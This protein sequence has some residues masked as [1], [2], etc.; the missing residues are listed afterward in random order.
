MD[1][2]AH[3][4][5]G[6]LAGVALGAIAFQGGWVDTWA[7]GAALGGLCAGFALFPDL[8]TASRPQRWAARALLVAVGWLAL[9]GRWREAALLGL[10]ALLPL[11][12]H[13]RGWTHRWWAVP[14][15]PLGALLLWQLLTGAPVTWAMASPAAAVRALGASAAAQGPAYLAMASG[16]ALHLIL[17]RSRPRRR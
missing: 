4:A 5:A 2:R 17:D 3:L 11:L 7:D 15:V 16:Y 14:L 8:D 6:A 13:H 10:A 12:T 9:A 1:G